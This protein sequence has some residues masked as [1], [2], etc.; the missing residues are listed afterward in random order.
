MHRC[1]LDTTFHTKRRHGNVLCILFFPIIMTVFFI[2]I[3]LQNP[4]WDNQNPCISSW[5]GLEI[6][7]EDMNK[8]KNHL[9]HSR[10]K[11]TGLALSPQCSNQV[12]NV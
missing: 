11:F 4:P 8:K 3:I 9:V 5:S 2:Y 7:L 1:L 12:G 6:Q 10:N